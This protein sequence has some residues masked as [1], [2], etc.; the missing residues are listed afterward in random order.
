MKA[1][2]IKGFR[3]KYTKEKYEEG[4]IIDVT[5]KRYKEIL[6]VDKLVEEVIEEESEE[7]G[8]EQEETE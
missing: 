3:D 5:K 6:K 2:V 4:T 8:E 1:R 7:N